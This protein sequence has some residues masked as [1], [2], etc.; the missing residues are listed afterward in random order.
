MFLKQY[1]AMK[2]GFLI[3]ILGSRRIFWAMKINSCWK[4]FH[5]K[6][7]IRNLF[8]FFQRALLIQ[9]GRGLNF[10]ATPK[11]RKFVKRETILFLSRDKNCC[12]ETPKHGLSK[13][14]AVWIWKIHLI[15]TATKWSERDTQ[16]AFQ[17]GSFRDS[18][19]P[20]YC[21][22]ESFFKF[23]FLHYG[24]NSDLTLWLEAG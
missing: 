10:T 8:S 17:V 15:Q 9:W 2:W 18:M 7:S 20:G 24:Q 13:G 21:E 4:P 14:P 11:Q 23:F 12:K 22:P 16:V 3:Y 6:S 5:I 19:S 1:Y